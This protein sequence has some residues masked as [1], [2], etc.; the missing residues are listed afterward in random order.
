MT[1]PA[2]QTWLHSP[3]QE[4]GLSFLEWT[5][6]WLKNVV[7]SSVT[8]K[9][10]P[11]TAVCEPEELE[12]WQLRDGIVSDA[13]PFWATT[14]EVELVLHDTSDDSDSWDLTLPLMP[15]K[16][17]SAMGHVVSFEKWHPTEFYIE[18]FDD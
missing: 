6:Q 18:G 2:T 11:S 3:L 16:T 8:A 7:I 1:Y 10:H 12:Y 15:T 14:P 17:I 13:K 5:Q 4:T 9:I